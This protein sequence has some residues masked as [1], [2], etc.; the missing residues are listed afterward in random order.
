MVPG[1]AVMA[2][3]TGSA[4]FTDITM[5]LEVAGFPSAQLALEVTI[6]LTWS[7]LAGL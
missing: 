7:L 3:E 4:V 1:F 6:Q 2:T 5:V